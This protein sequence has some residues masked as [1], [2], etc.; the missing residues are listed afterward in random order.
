MDRLAEIRR[1]PGVEGEE[2]AYFI[3]G[4]NTSDDLFMFL[5]KPLSPADGI[6]PDSLYEAEVLIEL[7]SGA[8]TGCAGVGGSP[9]D[10]VYLKVGVGP[11]EPV[12]ILDGEEV[13]LNLD[14]GNQLRTARTRPWRGRSP[15]ASNAPRRTSA[16]LCAWS[17]GRRSPGRR[18][19]RTRGICGS[20]SARIRLSKA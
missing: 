7:F 13:L 12:S 20:T 14:K 10:G 4:K 17:V 8:P 18:V 2:L 5:K 16:S 9:G 11:T 15:T 1:V 3:Q 6:E 19:R